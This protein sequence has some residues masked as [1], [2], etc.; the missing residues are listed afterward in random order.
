MKWTVCELDTSDIS[1]GGGR[2]GAAIRSYVRLW[3]NIGIIINN[4]VTL[5]C[6]R[7]LN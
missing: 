2:G 6:F 4:D 7:F 3:V 5:N 1:T